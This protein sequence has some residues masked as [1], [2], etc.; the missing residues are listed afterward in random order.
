MHRDFVRKSPGVALAGA[1]VVGFA[2]TRLIKNGLSTADNDDED[3]DDRQAAAHDFGGLMLKPGDP[4]HPIGPARR[5]PVG[6]LVH[7]LV[8]DGKAYAQGRSGSRQGDRVGESR[9][10]GAFPLR[11]RGGLLFVLAG[12]GV[13]ATG[14]FFALE[15]LVGPLLA[16]LLT[17]LIFAAIAGALGWWASEGEEGPMS[18]DT[19][20]IAAARIEAERARARLMS[21]AHELQERIS[22][23][24]L[25]KGRVGRRQDEGRRPAED[26]VDAVKRNPGAAGSVAAAR[27]AAVPAPAA[28]GPRR[29]AV[30]R[31]EDKS[32]AR[33]ARKTE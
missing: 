30:R 17:F 8:E 10:A 15:P 31:S 26:A 3:R 1:A 29:Q 9:S 11:C 4:V 13:L 20:Q 24:V 7:Q 25:A 18:K 12:F 27:N 21:S 28:D 33:K 14:V 6:E 22:P 2:L 32:R 19:P 23:R 5:S 16:G